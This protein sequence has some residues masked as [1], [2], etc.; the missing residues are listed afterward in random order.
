MSDLLFLLILTAASD[1]YINSLLL[2]FLIML[3]FSYGILNNYG[4]G[5][6]VLDTYKNLVEILF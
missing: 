5:N 1:Q 4:G 6:V 2:L 3:N